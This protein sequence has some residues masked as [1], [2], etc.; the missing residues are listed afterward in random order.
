MH[1]RDAM[2]QAQSTAVLLGTSL[3]DDD[4]VPLEWAQ[5]L[6]PELSDPDDEASPW[7]VFT[8]EDDDD[9][10]PLVEPRKG[11]DDQ[12]EPA[13]LD[14]FGELVAADD[15]RFDPIEDA[16]S[17]RRFQYLMDSP[18]Y[19]VRVEA[20]NEIAEWLMA[21]Y[22]G[23]PTRRPMPSGRGPQPTGRGSKGRRR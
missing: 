16:S 2:Q 11:D 15:L 5:P 8:G 1:V 21:D 9:G 17:R 12:R 19:T 6:T 7:L 23:R 20:L 22:A 18:R 4:G 13:Y 3:R 14:W 10:Q